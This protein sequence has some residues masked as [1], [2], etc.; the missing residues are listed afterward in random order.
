MLLIPKIEAEEDP[1]QRKASIGR[2][3]LYFK[4]DADDLLEFSSPSE[5]LKGIKYVSDANA[6]EGIKTEI[7]SISLKE[8]GFKS[9]RRN[10]RA[11]RR[12]KKFSW[13][14]SINASKHG[15]S[16]IPKKAEAKESFQ[17]KPD[18]Y[19]DM[20]VHL[21]GAGPDKSYEKLHEAWESLGSIMDKLYRED[22]EELNKKPDTSVLVNTESIS[23]GLNE[24]LKASERKPN[25]TESLKPL[26]AIGNM[27]QID[28]PN[29]SSKSTASKPNGTESFKPLEAIENK[30]AI[31]NRNKSLE[32][33]E[34]SREAKLIFGLLFG[35]G[36]SENPP[37][38]EGSGMIFEDESLKKDNTSTKNQSEVSVEGLVPTK[39]P[40][41]SSSAVSKQGITKRFGVQESFLRE[42][43]AV[44]VGEPV[45][46]EETNFSIS[47][48]MK[49][50]IETSNPIDISPGITST[51]VANSAL[52]SDQLKEFCI[53]LLSKVQKHPK[54]GGELS[55]FNESRDSITTEI[56]ITTEVKSARPE[57]STEATTKPTNREMGFIASLLHR[58]TGGRFRQ[59]SED[60]DAKPDSVTNL[61]ISS[62]EA[63][64]MHGNLSEEKLI[65]SNEPN[66][67]EFENLVTERDEDILTIANCKNFFQRMQRDAVFSK[68][69]LLDI[70]N[71][72]MLLNQD[73]SEFNI[74]EIKEETQI[75]KVKASFDPTK[76]ITKD[77]FSFSTST[78]SLKDVN[79]QDIETT[80][81]KT[82]GESIEKNRCQRKLK[83]KFSKM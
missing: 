19:L 17:S 75:R 46:D 11:T 6:T 27:D 81:G 35:G 78:I 33:A 3:L 28:N 42:P 1:F 50:A 47:T 12:G 56:T 83:R 13:E 67:T 79:L 34:K 54:S 52:S 37:L 40:V 57:V 7:P 45:K 53:S 51:L 66:H 59:I 16:E 48:E 2:K 9:L 65:A 36:N 58:I 26:E 4:Y 5:S 43:T 18:E 77:N 23:S 25:G 76:S 72:P 63:F 41:T 61:N 69:N 44:F 68:P 82:S 20:A 30:I 55:P 32:I 10:K 31:D 74:T 29:K 38:E 39:I 73:P 15:D 14:L 60:V 49:D 8:N 24:S 71:N 80:E 64:G 70:L 62:N 22:L 21:K